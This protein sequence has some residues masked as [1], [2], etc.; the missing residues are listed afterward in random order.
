MYVKELNSCD[1]LLN[2]LWAY[3]LMVYILYLDLPCIKTR[4]FMMEK[5]AFACCNLFI[6][7]GRNAEALD[8]IEKDGKFHLD[9]GVLVIVFQDKDYN[10]V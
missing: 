5:L 10:H 1:N 6:S 8:S 3:L 9:A 4:L 7:E 2:F